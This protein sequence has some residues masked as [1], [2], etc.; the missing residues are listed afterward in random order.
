MWK[1]NALITELPLVDLH[2]LD[3]ITRPKPIWHE[4]RLTLDIRT[5]RFPDIG[6]PT[7][8]LV[9]TWILKSDYILI[10]ER[11]SKRPIKS[12]TVVCYRHAKTNSLPPRNSFNNLKQLYLAALWLGALLSSP[13][14]R[15]RK[16]FTRSC[17]WRFGVKLRNS[18]HAGVMRAMSASD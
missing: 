17:L 9:D 18:I 11:S 3:V 6:N 13:T 12:V 2:G 14:L 5:P 1:A 7:F 15:M 4:A 10:H 16:S 8:G